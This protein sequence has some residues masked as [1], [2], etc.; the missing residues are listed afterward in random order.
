MLG[1]ILLAGG[2]AVRMGKDKALLQRGQVSLMEHILSLVQNR[3]EQIVI[4]RSE[5]QPVLNTRNQ[6]NIIWSTDSVYDQGPLQGIADAIPLFPDT[7]DHFLLLSCDLPYLNPQALEILTKP[8][9]AGYDG[10]C[11]SSHGKINPLIG[12]YSKSTL[13]RSCELIQKGEKRAMQLL[14]GKQIEIRSAPKTNPLLFEG[15]NTPEEYQAFL[16]H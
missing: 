15:V 12:M 11:V 2:Q 6:Q 4:M 16:S 1:A 7:Y 8:I 9:P 13:E 3:V 5:G 10:I 14:H